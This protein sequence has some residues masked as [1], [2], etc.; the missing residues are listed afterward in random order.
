MG[1]SP[2]H[3]APASR[4]CYGRYHRVAARRPKLYAEHRRWQNRCAP[5]SR[6]AISHH[7]KVLRQAGLVTL[8]RVSRENFYSLTLEPGLAALRHL[9]EQAEA[10]CT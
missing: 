10:S 4:P 6:P 3:R 5:L 1:L 7:L 9:V 8:E 2:P